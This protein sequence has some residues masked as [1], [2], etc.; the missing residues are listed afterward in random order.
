MRLFEIIIPIML[1]VWL[2]WPFVSGRQRPVYINL[3]PSGALLLTVAHL[4]IEKYRWQMLPIYFFV[5]LFFVLSIIDLLRGKPG[6][7]NRRSWGSVFSIIGLLLLMIAVALPVLLPVPRVPAPTGE[8]PVGTMT[9]VLVDASRKELYSDDP[10]DDRKFMIQTWYPAGSIQGLRQA[11]WME[12]AALIAPEIANWLGL[13]GF[14]LDHLVLARTNSYQDAPLNPD[15]GPYPVLL[16]SHGWGGFR[17]QNTYQMQELASHGYIVVG[18]EHP[19]GAVATV[20]PDGEIIRNNPR[21]LA[22]N[23]G[24]EEFT[25]N[26]QRLVD[27]W[28][29]DMSFTLDILEKRNAT[30]GDPLHGMVDLER[31]GVLGH[32]T[33]GGATIQFCGTDVRCDAGLPMDAFMA[34]VSNQVLE[35]G[36]SQPFLFLFSEDWSSADNDALFDQFYRNVDQSIGILTILGTSHYDFSDLPALSPLSPYLGLKGP[37]T[38]SRVLE[39]I[40]EYSLAFFNQTLKDIPSTLLDSPNPDYPEVRFDH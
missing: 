33:G 35:V 3:L 17:A 6:K 2:L 24:D 4:V 12:N 8:Y 39:I 11:P 14:F 22:G 26:A 30:P 7:Y 28:A 27:Q 16:F 1:V 32:S 20:F 34:P 13:P 37:L 19:F 21:A 10:S 23:G 25:Q 31:V 15:G 5:L 29:G 9:D 36:L 40:N 18:L 38:G